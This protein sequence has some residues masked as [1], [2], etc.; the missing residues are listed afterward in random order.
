MENKLPKRSE[1]S[2]ELTWNLTDIY[3]NDEAC[4]KDAAR[5]GELADKFAGY[6]GRLCESAATLLSAMKDYEAMNLVASKALRY[7][8]MRS[9]VDTANQTAQALKGK[10]GSLYVAAT[11]KMAFMEPELIAAGKE[12]IDRFY[13][14]C[15][16]LKY[17]KVTLDDIL[18]MEAH[19]QSSEIEAL[20]A[21][22]GEMAETAYNGFNMLSDADLKFPS[23][24]DENG[25]EVTITNGRFVPLEMSHDRNVRKET[26]EK[27]YSTYHAFR[28]TWATL[29][30]GQVKQQMFYARA[31]KYNSTF[32]AAVDP[33]NV[34]PDVCKNLI[35]SVHDNI[36]KMYRYVRLRKKMLGVDELHMYD[37]YAPMVS[38]YSP[39]YTIEEAKDLVLKATAPLGKDYTDV[40]KTA[41]TERWIDVVE[42]EG[43]RGGAYEEGVYGVHPYVLLN[44]N[45]TLDDVFTLAHEMGHAMH[46]H[47]SDANNSF[48]NANYAIFV[49][50]VA[51]TTN[52]VLLFNYLY[53]HATEKAEKEYL[54]NHF[55][56]SFKGTLFRQTMFGEFEM[57][58][59]ALAEAGTPLTADE[60]T[61]TYYEL[62]KF[63]FGPDMVSDE[64][65]G[66]EWERIPHFYYNF[67]VYQ[68][69]TSFSAA[70]AIT[71]RI[72]KEGE[73][74]VAPYKKF[75]SSGCTD[76]P[77]SLL[78]IAGVDL[79]TR[80]PVDDALAE[81]EATIEKMENLIK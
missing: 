69:A 11:T 14:E 61:K 67:Y 23:V 4:E 63:Y 65:I 35:A 39:K 71:S 75:L 15:P 2:E 3:T 79:S 52:E 62:N 45:G 7:A 10:L 37:V 21:S 59:N 22:S 17:Y 60:L 77:V 9:D 33:V 5:M 57:K 41:F 31:K 43:K 16:D 46:T 34:S 70:V 51:S 19:T 64:L 25:N 48:L 30:Y 44:F 55:L 6:E 1:V 49:A 54:L 73:S 36:E 58:T 74:A 66:D 80:K 38:D 56:D 81:F 40:L 27:Y 13:D 53:D 42:N 76:D 50:E 12:K 8:N 32:E 47:Y 24:K 18:R 78:K 68:Y 26:F 29:Y 28:N 72:L 20:L